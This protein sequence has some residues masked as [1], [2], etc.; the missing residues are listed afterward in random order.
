[1]LKILSRRGRRQVLL[2]FWRSSMSAVILW[3]SHKEQEACRRCSLT[4]RGSL[5]AI[6]DDVDEEEKKKQK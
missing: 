5:C 1:M 2:L 6:V 4:L 3:G